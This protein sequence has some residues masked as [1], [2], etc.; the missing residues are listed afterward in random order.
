[1]SNAPIAARAAPSGADGTARSNSAEVFARLRANSEYVAIPL[2]ALFIA[3]CLF[4]I[5]LIALGKS[6][7]DYIS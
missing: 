2:L 6:P 3:A 5:F 4:A 1:M 7:L